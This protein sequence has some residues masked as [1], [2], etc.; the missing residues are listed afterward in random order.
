MTEDRRNERRRIPVTSE[1]LDRQPPFDL[2]AEM[3]VIGSMML[4]TDFG[5]QILT[6]VRGEDFYDDANRGIFEAIVSLLVQGRPVD[7]QLLTDRLKSRGDFERVG[8][9]AYMAEVVKSV[10]HAFHITYYAD[11]VSRHA[12]RR[13]IITAATEILRANYEDDF[14]GS[15]EETVIA[16]DAEDLLAEALQ[17]RQVKAHRAADLFP[18]VGKRIRA[19]LTGEVETSEAI[20]TGLK[21]LDELIGGLFPRDLTVLA[22][23]PS[24]GKTAMS[25]QIAATI[26]YATTPVVFVSIEMDRDDLAMRQICSWA[27]INMHRVRTGKATHADAWLVEEIAGDLA[28]SKLVIVDQDDI[29]SREIASVAKQIKRETSGPVVIMVDY[30]GLV[31]FRERGRR[32]EL[33][34]QFMKQ[35]KRLARQTNSPVVLLSQLNRAVESDKDKRPR[36]SHLRES[37]DIEQDADNILFLHR[38]EY[39]EPKNPD[40]KGKAEVIVAK[41]R[42]GPTNSVY[43]KF[44][45]TTLTFS[46]IEAEGGA[47]EEAQ[48]AWDQ[49]QQKDL[50]F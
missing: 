34:G 26:A 46:D 11:I 25:L 40:V 43:L 3:C 24:M 4:A 1:I 23:R 21:A 29:D 6:K 50:G 2:N 15:Q 37:G 47:D 14:A 20:P 30:I 31:T 28:Q 17:L 45:R 48:A 49:E 9:H 32:N 33:V 44:S 19:R 38:P 41:N 13:R 39:Y 22:A 7:S 12:L 27:G 5:E 10:P 18:D 16:A 35:M 42:N 36:L 8:G